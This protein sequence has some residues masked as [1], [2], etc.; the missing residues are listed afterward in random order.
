MS[1]S[2]NSESTTPHVIATS[3]T[4]YTDMKGKISNIESTLNIKFL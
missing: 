2:E 3:T 1:F 4:V